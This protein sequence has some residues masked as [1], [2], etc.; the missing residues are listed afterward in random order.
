[1]KQEDL[2]NAILETLPDAR[3]AALW[4]VW[5]DH[6]FERSIR[7]GALVQAIRGI[8]ESDTTEERGLRESFL[9]YLDHEEFE[10]AARTLE[11]LGDREDDAGSLR[12]DLAEHETEALARY[13]EREAE[14]RA[15][16]RKEYLENRLISREKGEELKAEMQVAANRAAGR[17]YHRAV[18]KL[19]R[20]LVD[21]R[22]ERERRKREL[23]SWIDGV[24]LE[25]GHP[26]REDMD[27]CLA[28]VRTFLDRSDIERAEEFKGRFL[29]F[30]QR[31]PTD[32]DRGWL[33]PARAGHL[34]SRLV[35]PAR[36]LK[37]ADLVQQMKRAGD[38]RSI[39]TFRAWE[40]LG[41]GAGTQHT[42][43]YLER[44]M[45]WLSRSAVDPA[46]V[47]RFVTKSRGR[48]ESYPSLY[49]MELD[50]PPTIL[51]QLYSHRESPL[52]LYW[53]PRNFQLSGKSYEFDLD[54]LERFLDKKTFPRRE[55][56]GSGVTGEKWRPMR[57]A[58]LLFD[59]RRIFSLLLV[60]A[61]L[62]PAEREA[63]TRRTRMLVLDDH[64]MQQ[65]CLTAP[66]G[67]L[68]VSPARHPLVHAAVRPGTAAGRIPVRCGGGHAREP[69]V[70]GSLAR[71]PEDLRQGPLTSG[72]ARGTED[73]QVQPAAQGRGDGHP[74]RVAGGTGHP[75]LP[76]PLRRA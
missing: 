33:S 20:I 54:A 2:K 72:R 52:A 43:G 30:E 69:A 36:D 11:L 7:R 68:P 9:W 13:R 17:R 59:T 45:A 22:N 23:Q 70:H 16:L 29:R 12:N 27:R 31:T 42:A 15:C 14:V 57:T 5:P 35:P 73:R 3:W 8:L 34:P 21:I 50:Y 58:D 41:K 66:G 75:F 61:P 26:F 55:G 37:P 38:T 6:L 39:D 71:A 62:S 19:D 28:L 18:R 4:E 32:Q 49:V 63:I 10:C 64:L 25:K 60:P 24:N 47:V 51:P 48:E 65:L 44:I 1:M 56:S 74:L 67:S 76:R 40:S 53:L 46:G